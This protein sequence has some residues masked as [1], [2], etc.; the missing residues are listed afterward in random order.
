MVRSH[1]GLAL[2]FAILVGFTGPAFAADA[3]DA[4]GTWKWQMKRGDNTVDVTLKLKQEGEKLTG[5]ISGRENSTTEIADGKAK[6][7]NVS[8]KVT[9]KGR[10]NQDIVMTYTGKV[11]GDTLKAKVE[12]AAPGGEARTREFEAKRS[13]E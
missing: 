11:E 8:F 13:K 5:T 4:T 1:I 9:R 3:N 6:D 2:A 10:D 12:F 7:G